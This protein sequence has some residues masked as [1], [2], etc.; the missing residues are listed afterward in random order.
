MYGIIQMMK[1]VRNKCRKPSRSLLTDYDRRLMVSRKSSNELK[2]KFPHH[3]QKI[4]VSLNIYHEE[5]TK[6]IDQGYL[7]LYIWMC[8]G[9]YM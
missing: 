9:R 6:T 5:N 4:N 8:D 1:Q 2:H 7:Y 3:Q